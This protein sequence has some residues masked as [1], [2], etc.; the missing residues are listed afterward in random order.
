[1]TIRRALHAALAVLVVGFLS[2]EALVWARLGT[3]DAVHAADPYVS[4][5]HDGT[6]VFWSESRDVRVP[7]GYRLEV[8]SVDGSPL[9]T[10]DYLDPRDPVTNRYFTRGFPANLNRNRSLGVDQTFERAAFLPPYAPPIGGDELVLSS[11]NGWWRY[12]D[13]PQVGPGGFGVALSAP[14]STDARRGRALATR[15]TFESGRFIGRDD[16]GVVRSVIGPGGRTSDLEA[17][18]TARFGRL[19]EFGQK[20]HRRENRPGVVHSLFDADANQLVRI[21]VARGEGG[22]EAVPDIEVATTPLSPAAPGA[23]PLHAKVSVV[24]MPGRTIGVD[25]A[26]TVWFDFVAAADERDL[27]T[28]VKRYLRDPP[29]TGDEKGFGD[30][31]LVVVAWSTIERGDPLVRHTRLRHQT[32]GHALSTWD[33]AWEPRGVA[34]RALVGLACVPAVLR[35]LPLAAASFLSGPPTDGESGATWWWLDPILAGRRRPIVLGVNALVAALC[36]FFAWRVARVHC[37]TQVLASAWAAAGFLLG[38]LGLLLLR[39]LVVRAPAETVGG[40]R[41]S[42][43]LDACPATDVPWPQP[44]RTGREIIAGG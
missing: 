19:F 32:L 12:L 20:N 38:P 2:L 42:L 15:F 4:V 22:A 39:L 34:Q 13:A 5:T 30:T 1:M 40:G 41:R 14:I 18:G 44:A 27:R 9:A 23:E 43:R 31:P 35:P 26:G 36:V 16:L 17:S 37:A 21:T 6:P 7:S 29:P 24:S 28:T 8:W 11:L 25:E 10:G 33:L 3:I